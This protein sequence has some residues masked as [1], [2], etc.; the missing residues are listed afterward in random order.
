MA[1]G[2]SSVGRIKRIAVRFSRAKA[3][4]PVRIGL[5][6]VGRWGRNFVSTIDQLS[7]AT[8]IRVASRNPDTA[9]FLK[10]SCAVTP[11]WRELLD[12]SI[13]AVIVATPPSTHAK[14]VLEAVRAG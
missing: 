3:L 2:V 1:F 13:D 10:S 7:D 8:L 6:G 11:N 9:K 12:D 14:I 4:Q 5:V